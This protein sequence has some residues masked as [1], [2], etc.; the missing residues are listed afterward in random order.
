MR[1]YLDL[2][3]R[4]K[5][6][7]SMTPTYSIS[8][9]HRWTL[10]PCAPIRS[11]YGQTSTAMRDFRWSNWSFFS[12]LLAISRQA[13]DVLCLGDPRWGKLLPLA[14]TVWTDLGEADHY[15]GKVCLRSCHLLI[16]I[17][18][19]STPVFL[20]DSACNFTKCQ[21]FGDMI[22]ASET[23]THVSALHGLFPSHNMH[24]SLWE[25]ICHNIDQISLYVGTRSAACH[26]IPSWHF[27]QEAEIHAVFVKGLESVVW[28]IHSASSNASARRAFCEQKQSVWTQSFWLFG[29]NG[30]CGPSR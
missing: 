23:F 16:S 3:V 5:N 24:K 19:H 4:D 14:S 7:N 30:P 9:M 18:R 11:I 26:N 25:W 20:H 1:F 15:F 22:E 12:R 13:A 10:V 28:P 27:I 29:K 8:K 21:Y 2:I 17:L 6:S